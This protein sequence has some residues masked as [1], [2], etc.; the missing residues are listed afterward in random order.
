M[1]M[2]AHRLRSA[3]RA[4]DL[5]QTEVADKVGVKQGYISRLERGEKKPSV[6][7]LS[8]LAA[9]YGVSESYLL[10]HATHEEP[11]PYRPKTYRPVVDRDTPPGLR[12]LAADSAL[13]DSLAVTPAEWQT[14]ASIALPSPIDKSG[15]VQL[16]TT[17]RGISRG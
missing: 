17:I 8:R 10:G 11:A 12:E 5:C 9:L 7:L 2:L 16:L 13:M 14:L 1:A 3:R 4:K 6:E 15:Y